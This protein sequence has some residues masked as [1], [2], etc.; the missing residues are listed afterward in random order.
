MT[1]SFP[2]AF[3]QRIGSSSND[4]YKFLQ[5]DRNEVNC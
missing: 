4:K 5:L 2:E 1:S 3:L